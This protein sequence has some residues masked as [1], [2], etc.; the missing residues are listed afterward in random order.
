MEIKEKILE[1]SKRLENDTIDVKQARKEFN[2]AFGA[3]HKPV[4]KGLAK[5][6]ESSNFRY[7]GSELP[8]IGLYMTHGKDSGYPEGTR[9]FRLNLE[10]TVHQLETGYKDT[11]IPEHDLEI[12]ELQEL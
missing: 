9:E 10:G 7:R 1:I 3:S 8:I 2:A 6:K 5:V 11:V 4:W 12:L